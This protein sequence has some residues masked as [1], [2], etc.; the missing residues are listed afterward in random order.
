MKDRLRTAGVSLIVAVWSLALFAANPDR[1]AVRAAWEWSDEERIQLR[2]EEGHRQDREST[3]GSIP[4]GKHHYVIDG[5]KHPELFTPDELFSSLIGSLH[6]ANE[7]ERQTSMAL[8]TEDLQAEGFDVALFWLELRAIVVDYFLQL[9]RIALDR[10]ALAKSPDHDREGQ[11]QVLRSD[12][13]AACRA[14]FVALQDARRV[15]GKERFDRFLYVRVASKLSSGQDG[16][17][18]DE[19]EGMRFI[20]RGCR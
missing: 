1:G 8:R 3:D 11:E 2:I 18:A 10:E 20:A 14:R 15:F 6:L 7:N 19:A 5:S 13:M 4:V 12:R 9:D 16:S 17:F